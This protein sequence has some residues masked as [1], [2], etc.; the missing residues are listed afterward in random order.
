MV[1]YWSDTAVEILLGVCTVV[2]ALV[3]LYKGCEWLFRYDDDILSWD[4][5]PRR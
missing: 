2:P 5:E 1:A 4:E 3:A